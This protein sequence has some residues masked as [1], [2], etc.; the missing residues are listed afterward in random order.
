[1]MFVYWFAA[2]FI[3]YAIIIHFIKRYRDNY[4]VQSEPVVDYSERNLK[5]TSKRKN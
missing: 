1:M 2:V 5:V 4:R 3:I